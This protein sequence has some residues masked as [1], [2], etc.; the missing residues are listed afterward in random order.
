[1]NNPVDVRSVKYRYFLILVIVIV[2]LL[3]CAEIKPPPGGPVDKTK[4]ALIQ[5]IPAD[6]SVNVPIDNKIELV[7]SEKVVP[8]STGK[9]I[10]ISPRPPKAPKIK[11]KGERVI[12]ILLDSFRTNETYIVSASSAITDLRG[13]KLDS[14]GILAF[15]TGPQIDTGIVS[16]QVLTGN[17]P[18]VGMLV[19]LYH[20]EDITDSTKFDSLYPV[21]LVQTS[22]NG[23]FRFRYLP[24]KKFQLI[25]F[26]DKNHNELFNP[27]REE[28]AVSDRLIDIGGDITL[29]N[30][31]LSTTSQDTLL[32]EI[33][34][35]TYTS[36]SLMHV[37]FTRPIS[38]E[39][40]KKEPSRIQLSNQQNKTEITSAI[41]ILET[42]T[43]VSSIMV[44]FGNVT[45]GVYTISIPYDT[46]QPTLTYPD[47][48]VER[49]ED[50]ASP[51]VVAFSPDKSPVLL[52]RL[53]LQLTF[54][55]PLD[56]AKFTDET[57]VLWDE[58]D[59]PLPLT[60]EWKD[61]FRLGLFSPDI[62][63]G[64]SYRLTV[65]EF[66]LADNAGN[67]VGDSLRE[68][69][70][71]IY[72]SKSFGS[73]SGTIAVDIPGKQDVPVVLHCIKTDNNEDYSIVVRDTT[74]SVDVP[75]GK[76]ML[77]GFLDSDGNNKRGNGSVI[78]FRLAETQVL[79]PDT[80]HVRARFETAGI[81]MEFK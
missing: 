25:A 5:S 61:N 3:G 36:N 74:F 13:N 75:S 19:G 43:A 28:F 60:R 35:V 65:T 57:L 31:L 48:I 10:F 79:F 24:S 18:R 56:T 47:V 29:D 1:M 27:L 52:N 59:N 33:L 72:D 4:P 6:G 78:P 15:S 17:T 23:Q 64:M 50:K 77:S 20:A 38:V 34:S 81:L 37:R 26:D 9:S 11:W 66:E 8:P 51:T 80:I 73:I 44:N 71:S 70:F 7:F 2:F 53:H 22:S 42:D 63:E 32:P 76:Y 68:Y 62:K 14:T 40:L 30:L 58:Q 67:V 54:S 41:D 49:K 45:P 55:E 16:G 12:V 69:T 46:T 21:Y 39:L